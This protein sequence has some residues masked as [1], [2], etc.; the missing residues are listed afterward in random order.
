MNWD[1]IGAVAELLGAI[2]VIGSLV[3]LARQIASNSANINHNTQALV[4]STDISSNE[5][6]LQI[7]APQVSDPLVADLMIR[8]YQDFDGLDRVDKYRFS[9]MLRAMFETHQTYFLLALRGIAGEQTWAYYSRTF[10]AVS[11]QPGV[12][13]WWARNGRSFD[14]EFFDYIDGKIPAEPG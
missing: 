4:A 5:L 10:D 11:R 13:Q 14:A 9:T 6:V 2:G 7:Y 8:G 12:R 3:Y 1:A